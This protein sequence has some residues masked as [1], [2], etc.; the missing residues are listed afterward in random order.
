MWCNKIPISGLFCSR[1]KIRC[2]ELLNDAE[3][4]YN[5]FLGLCKDIYVLKYKVLKPSG[6]I[7]LALEDT[8]CC[9]YEEAGKGKTAKI[10]RKFSESEQNRQSY[11]Y[12]SHSSD[13]KIMSILGN[14]LGKLPY[15]PHFWFLFH[16]VCPQQRSYWPRPTNWT[17]P[18]ESRTISTETTG[19]SALILVPI[20]LCFSVNE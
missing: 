4:T 16:V 18:E 11:A 13:I 2:W 5:Y 7:H 6:L 15:E 12:K 20:T 3:H 1:P 17:D 9:R 14:R 10:R 19:I 8:F